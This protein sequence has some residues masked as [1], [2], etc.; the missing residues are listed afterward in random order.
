MCCYAD[1]EIDNREI[2]SLKSNLA[3]TQFVLMLINSIGTG[4]CYDKTRFS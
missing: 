3:V 1:G 2:N 4:I